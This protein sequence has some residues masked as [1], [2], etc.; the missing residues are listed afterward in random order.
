MR[1]FS[2][3]L[4]TG[5]AAGHSIRTV[6][7]SPAS[8]SLKYSTLDSR[9]YPTVVQRA[10]TLCQTYGKHAR[11]ASAPVPTGQDTAVA[12]FDCVP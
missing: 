8:V 12:T 11:Q 6:S 7:A 4:L 5:C 9:E 1:V 10:E 2:L 3:L